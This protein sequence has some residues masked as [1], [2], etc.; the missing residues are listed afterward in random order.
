MQ[1]ML[2]CVLLP[3]CW[4]CAVVA[5]FFCKELWAVFLPSMESL[6]LSIT[7]VQLTNFLSLQKVQ[8]QFDLLFVY[9]QLQSCQSVGFGFG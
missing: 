2:T 8:A 4:T 3:G 5:C 1:D 9:C 7:H 6:W